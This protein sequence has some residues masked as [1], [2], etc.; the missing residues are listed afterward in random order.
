MTTLKWLISSQLK[1]SNLDRKIGGFTLIELLVGLLLA[2][3]VLVPLLGFMIDI[4]NNDR[5]EQAKATSEQE[6]QSGLDYI[7]RDLQQAA[8]IYDGAGINAIQT[9]LPGYGVSN[10]F[11]VLVFWKRK[12]VKQ[13]LLVPSSTP[14]GT[15][16][17]DDSFVYSLVAYYLVKGSPND[18][19]WSSTAR[20]GRYEVSDGI[21]DV[22]GV[23]CPGYT[24]TYAQ[25]GSTTYCPDPGFALFQLTNSTGSIRQKMNAWTKNTSAAYTAQIQT[26]I[27]YVDTTSLA[28]APQ[29]VDCNITI[30]SISPST[31]TVTETPLPT[32]TGAI[33]QAGFF[34]CV[35]SLDSDN[36]SLAQVYLRG[37]ALARIQQNPPGYSDNA[38]SYFPTANVRVEGHS[39]I[40]TQ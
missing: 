17:R 12:F 38:K 37:N 26:L 28:H 1:R 14:G 5:K 23:A 9:Q 25:N 21:R 31:N 7:A 36:R 11:P 29:K 32:L 27:D 3:L 10:Q 33:E 2:F 20:I 24:D 22:N 34:A 4:L 13:A 30:N 6:I 19:T 35:N 18:T 16:T 15:A 40:F 39:F 8:Y